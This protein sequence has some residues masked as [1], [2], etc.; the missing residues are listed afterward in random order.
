MNRITYIGHATLCLEL[1]GLRIL[2]DPLLMRRVTHLFR[3]T[4]RPNVKGGRVDA[5][6]ISHLHGDHVHLPSLR[7]LGHGIPIIAPRGAAAFFARKGFHNVTELSAGEAV[8]LNGVTIE[9]T[10]ADHG[11]RPFPMRPDTV[12]LGYRI[13]A[14]HQ[15]YFAGDTDLFDDMAAIGEKVDVAL[16][17]VWGYGPTLGPGHLDPYRAAEALQLLQPKVAVPIHWGTYFPAGL[18][19][20]LPHYLYRPPREFVAYADQLAPGVRT[21]ILEP[22]QTLT[23]TD[24]DRYNHETGAVEADA[25]PTHPT[26]VQPILE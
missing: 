14:S 13:L 8:H 9:A 16:L 2:T 4:P 19:Q 10:W 20:V 17:P 24:K 21:P 23:L 22:G 11:G 6:L 18:H 12:A 7:R 26:A 5:I 1:D 25:G 15:V 3:I